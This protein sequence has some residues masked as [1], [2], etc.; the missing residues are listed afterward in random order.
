MNIVSNKQMFYRRFLTGEFGNRVQQ[1]A[2]LG[3]WKKSQFK[4]PIGIR[5]KIR[6][7]RFDP[8][9]QP[10]DVE[11][12]VK[13]FHRQGYNDLNFSEMLDHSKQL[14]NAEVCRSHR[15]LEILYSTVRKPMRDAL[16]EQS[17]FEHGLQAALV[18]RKYL[19]PV[20]REWV[21]H[22]LDTY[23]DHVVEFTSMRIPCGVDAWRGSRTVIWE[24]RK[25]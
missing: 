24:V 8:F 2:T 7:G 3:E 18:L 25:Y 10:A 17:I 11:S 21:E 16:Q 22:L 4:G 9:V 13:E 19:T 14:I 12:R 5:T 6:G 20:D 1:W 15:G 23:V